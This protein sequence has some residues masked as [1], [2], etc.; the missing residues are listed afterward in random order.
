[1]QNPAVFE[2]AQASPPLTGELTSARKSNLGPL[3]C[4]ILLFSSSVSLFFHIKGLPSGVTFPVKIAE[5]QQNALT[6]KKQRIIKK[7]TFFICLWDKNFGKTIDRKSV[8]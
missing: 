8:V 5:V 4:S 7:D 1:M 6:V 3:K 2:P